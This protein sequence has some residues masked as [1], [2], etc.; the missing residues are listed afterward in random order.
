MRG[1]IQRFFTVTARWRL[2]HDERRILLGLTQHEYRALVATADPVASTAVLERIEAVLALDEIVEQHARH[3]A[4]VDRWLRA[5]L[6]HPPFQG[7]TPLQVLLE[8][9][10]GPRVLHSAL[11]DEAARE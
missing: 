5:P 9:R 7:V 8:R 1:E 10:D 6:D 3:W 4:H 2:S 11:T